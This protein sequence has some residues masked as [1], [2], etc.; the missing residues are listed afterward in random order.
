MAQKLDFIPD[1]AGLDFQPDS[2]GLDFQP[3]TSEESSS[4]LPTIA[5]IAPAVLGGIVGGL[6]GGAGGAALGEYLAQK[7]E[8]GDTNL[9]QVGLAAALGLIPGVKAAG[10]TSGIGRAALRVGEGAAMGIGSGAASRAVEG[11]EIMPSKEQF[12]QEAGLGALFGAGGA[13]LERY[14]RGRAPVANLAPDAAPTP[15]ADPA[16]APE[17]LPQHPQFAP[18]AAVPPTEEELVM[19][20]M[21]RPQ[22]NDIVAQR[23]ATGYTPDFPTDTSDVRGVYETMHGTNRFHPE[24]AAI[25]QAMGEPYLGTYGTYDLAPDIARPLRADQRVHDYAVNMRPEYPEQGLAERLIELSSIQPRLGNESDALYPGLAAPKLNARD[26]ELAIQHGTTDPKKLKAL[27]QK[28]RKPSDDAPVRT[29]DVGADLTGI[30]A[31]GR[32]S[33][34]SSM[35]GTASSTPLVKTP[36]KWGMMLRGIGQ[37]SSN[38]IAG[39][40]PSGAKLVDSVRRVYDKFEGELAMYLDGPQ[41][42]VHLSNQMKL[43][44][45][46]RENIGHVLEG[47]APAMNTRTAQLSQIMKTQGAMIE[48][49]ATG[50]ALEIRDPVTGAKIPWQARQNFFPHF[51]DFDAVAKDQG[52]L[53][54]VVAEIQKQ[55]SL[56]RQAQGKPPISN[57]EAQQIFNIMRDRSRMEYGHLEIARRYDF[58][59]YE[60]DAIKS[61]ARYSEGALKRLNEAEVFG[62]QHKDALDLVANIGQETGNDMAQWAAQTYFD[63]VTGRT[64]QNPITSAVGKSLRSLQ[65]GLKLGQAVIAN[66][67]QSN[68]TGIVTG[69]GNLLKGFNELR[70]QSGQE[71]ARLAGATIEQTLR[72][73]NDSLGV[74]QFGGKVLKATGFARIEQF[75][76][77]LA[78]NAGKIFAH[79]LINKIKANGSHPLADTWKRH[80]RTMGIEPMDVLQRGWQLSK[81]EELK[82]ARSVIARTQFKVRSQ[83]LPLF[84]NGPMG[85]LVTQFSSFGFKATKAIKDEVVNET[86]KGNLAP[87]ARFVLVTPIVG[88]GV[89]KVQDL[90]KGHDAPETWTES[91]IEAYASVG[92]MGLFYDAW[93]A[94][95]YGEVGVLRRMVGPNISDFAQ[96]ASGTAEIAQYLAAGGQ[97]PGG[98]DKAIPTR[99]ARFGTQNIPIVGPSL[100]PRIFPPKDSQ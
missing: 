58:S 23:R 71:F 73:M 87:L 68:L 96:V 29:M 31:P 94:S 65:V 53:T 43:S 41:G 56:K 80:L 89:A 18:R 85:K 99:L 54:K 75:N 100:R 34:W 33:F 38:M 8:G 25:H 12:F 97:T 82:A 52:R 42:I 62:R 17:P 10:I 4:I 91:I 66:A 21:G 1:D 48:S 59:D 88:A 3:D 76:R 60:R 55:E 77:M 95:T 45:K 74:G 39:L 51:M 83:E 61:W 22:P 37:E 57:G 5:R 20:L 15:V 78:A 11:Q 44:P 81:D 14:M 50:S 13:G 16:T 2:A 28:P 67:S 19:S 36:G 32:V 47:L 93:R 49:R 64:S 7:L 26:I 79:D 6:P 98:A 27:L 72:D 40:G 86:R 24:E 46:E 70:T 69:Y 84:W 35:L 63:Q 30:G 9:K 90:V 92:A